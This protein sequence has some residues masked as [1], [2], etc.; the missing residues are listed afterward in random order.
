[1]SWLC[2]GMQFFL[3]G[4]GWGGWRKKMRGPLTLDLAVIQGQCGCSWKG[5][6]EPGPEI[7]RME[8]NFVGMWHPRYLLCCISS[9]FKSTEQ[10]ESRNIQL[11]MNLEG[12]MYMRVYMSAWPAFLRVHFPELDFQVTS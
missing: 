12:H 3:W 8:C 9:D 2:Q 1:M 5:S 6:G 7:E 11:T 4:G 10:G